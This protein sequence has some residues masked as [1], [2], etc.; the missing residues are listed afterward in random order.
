MVLNLG[1]VVQSPISTYP[2]ITLNKTY[3]VNLGL[4][5]IRL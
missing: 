1:Q 2:E 5:L 3:G 4:L